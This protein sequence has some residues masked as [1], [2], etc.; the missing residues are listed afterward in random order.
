MSKYNK[1]DAEYLEGSVRKVLEP[2]IN[3]LN[4]SKPK[5]PLLFM[6]KWVKMYLGV[7]YTPE[8]L[9]L[10]EELESLRK[11][12]K[13]Y[14]K[15]YDKERDKEEEVSSDDEEIDP[16][17]QERI[18]QMLDVNS[19]K[20][21]AQRTSVSAEAF[22]RFNQKA[23]Y[24]PI[25]I[26]KSNE[27]KEIIK[28]KMLQDFLFNHLDEREL[29]TVIDAFEERK[30]QANQTVITQGAIEADEVYL[31]E[32]GELDCSKK[33]NEVETYLKTYI[34]GQS[35][36]ELALLYNAPRAATIVSKTNCVL[37]ALNRNCFNAII[38]NSAIRKRGEYERFLQ[39]VEILQTINQ[40]EIGQLCD[41]IKVEI[42]PS[43]TKIIT[44][45]EEGNMFY[46]LEEGEAYATKLING[47]EKTVLEYKKGSYFG[48]LSLL[49][50]EPRAASVYAKI[51]CR[52]LT[53]DRMTFKRILG[54]L[55]VILERNFDAY[56][57]YLNK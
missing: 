2:L 56:I 53:L 27:R 55:Q 16:E 43:G 9:E 41:A 11:E 8:E 35:F 6:F 42:A 52:L 22:G 1:A 38:R 3:N 50:D 54:P 17:E 26:P 36:G 45:N 13:K 20:K 12:I 46:F 5:D 29:D 51:E 15:K 49:K 7:I 10:K 14:Q 28:K 25:V 40:Y 48:E 44:Q 33:I 30:I 47:K 31:V 57:K 34:S 37:W 21:S 24:T 4:N 19:I 18:N 39:S 32:S 23:E